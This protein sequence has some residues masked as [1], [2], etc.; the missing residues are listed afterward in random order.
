M[1][2]TY[3]NIKR[4]TMENLA[5]DWI[6]KG[7]LDREYKEYLVLAYEQK[8][9]KSFQNL[10]LFP[11]L[12]NVKQHLENLTEIYNKSNLI[13][14]SLGQKLIHIDWKNRKLDYQKKVHCNDS[15]EELKLIIEF[16]LPKFQKLHNEGQSIDKEIRK[17]ISIE[18]LGVIPLYNKE[19]YIVFHRE[20]SEYMPVY[21]YDAHIISQKAKLPVIKLRRLE[22]L[23]LSSKIALHQIKKFLVNRF[24]DLPN[25]ATY[26]LHSS[27][28]YPVDQTLV[29][30]AGQM[31]VQRIIY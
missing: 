24:E 15:I 22:K 29:P 13:D 30:I 25:P 31:L 23:Q 4:K 7:W 10:Y 21:R 26:L 18:N 5:F 12:Y 2:S 16:S 9:K 20:D 6:Y 27:K 28:N 11:E 17:Q 8:V 1:K 3:S 14:N 19:G